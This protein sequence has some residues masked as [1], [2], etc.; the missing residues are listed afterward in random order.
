MTTSRW[1]YG[2]Q[3][4]LVRIAA[5][6]SMPVMIRHHHVGAGRGVPLL[7]QAGEPRWPLMARSPLTPQ[8]EELTS[9]SSRAIHHDD[10]DRGH[11]YFLRGFRAVRRSL[12][13]RGTLRGVADPD[14][15]ASAE[16]NV[17]AT[18]IPSFVMRNSRMRES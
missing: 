17:S 8:H 13:A 3:P 2:S 5:I 16:R 11:G 18:S 7:L 12:G 6:I 4:P 15:T 1:P 14:S 9:I 10:Q